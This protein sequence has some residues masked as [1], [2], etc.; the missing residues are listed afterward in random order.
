MGIITFPYFPLTTLPLQ[1]RKPV[2]QSLISSTRSPGLPTVAPQFPCQ[3]PQVD[4]LA[5]TSSLPPEDPLGSLAPLQAS[6]LPLSADHGP[7]PK[8]LPF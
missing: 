8:L 2:G 7:F 1:A 3:P 6:L 5:L 4:I